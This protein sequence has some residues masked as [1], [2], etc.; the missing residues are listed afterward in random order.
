[1]TAELFIVG[2]FALAAG[3]CWWALRGIGIDPP[4]AWLSEEP[5]TTVVPFRKRERRG[6]KNQDILAREET[7]GCVSSVLP[8]REHGER[9]A[10]FQ[11][12]AWA[13]ADERGRLA[14]FD[15]RM[16]LY[17]R[18]EVALRAAAPYDDFTVVRVTVTALVTPRTTTK[19]RRGSKSAT[20]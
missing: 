6:V 11:E 10:M 15:G 20:R 1:M 18:R 3:F 8:R 5:K 12:K 4:A 17:W 16:P 7:T 14:V 19:R 9:S 13:I 2:M